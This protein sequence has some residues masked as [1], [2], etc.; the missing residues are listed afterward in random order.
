MVCAHLTALIAG[1]GRLATW[2]RSG[3]SSLCY[4]IMLRRVREPQRF[5]AAFRI[6]PQAVQQGPQVPGRPMVCVVR[7][8]WWTGKFI[9]RTEVHSSQPW[10]AIWAS[11]KPPPP[12]FLF[13][14]RPEET[15]ITWTCISFQKIYRF[16]ASITALV[17]S[18]ITSKNKLNNL[19]TIL[20]VKAL[21]H[22]ATSR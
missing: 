19:K 13:L 20:L 18:V 16:T 12:L 4:Y 10:T 9:V 2:G 5:G 11:A 7:V 6:R 1:T 21:R 17:I 8:A 15:I 22:Y 14:F 3:R